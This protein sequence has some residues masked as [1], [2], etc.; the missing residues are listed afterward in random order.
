MRRKK[1]E[2]WARGKKYDSFL[3][4]FPWKRL[5]K[6]SITLRE[7]DQGRG[8]GRKIDSVE[9]DAPVYWFVWL[10]NDLDKVGSLLCLCY[11]VEWKYISS[12]TGLLNS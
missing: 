6:K 11:S 10:A 4:L 1:T 2:K 7:F 5:G 3:K 9:S 8:R 12:L